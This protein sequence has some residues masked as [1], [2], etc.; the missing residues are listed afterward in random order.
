MLLELI[1]KSHKKL[2]GAD[3]DGDA[4]IVIPNNRGLIKTSA[5]LKGLE[6]FDPITAYK[7]PEGSNIPP[8]KPKTKQT[9]MGEVSNL[10]TD[11]TIKGANLDEMQ[12]S[13]SFYGCYRF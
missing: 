13:S 5:S 8:I 1:L 6:N 9:K 7:I 10:I 3:F 2:S 11:M 4:V 12:S